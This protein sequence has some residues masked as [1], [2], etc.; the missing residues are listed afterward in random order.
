[1]NTLECS[2]CDKCGAC[3]KCAHDGGACPPPPKVVI[4]HAQPSKIARRGML[5]SFTIAV[6]CTAAAIALTVWGK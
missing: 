1:M 5:I 6:I 2:K 3:V 4:R